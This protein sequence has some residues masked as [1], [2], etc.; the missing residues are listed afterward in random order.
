MLQIR[1]FHCLIQIDGLTKNRIT[2]EV[3]Y[4]KCMPIDFIE[5]LHGESL[6]TMDSTEKL[7][8]KHKSHRRSLENKA[9][10]I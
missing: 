7:L 1:Y 9:T 6:E 8:C 2:L 5:M 4:G 3:C 10:V